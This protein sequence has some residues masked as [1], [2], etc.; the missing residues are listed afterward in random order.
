MNRRQFIQTGAVVSSAALPRS[1]ARSTQSKRSTSGGKR[2]ALVAGEPGGLSRTAFPLT[3]GIPFAPG[4]LPKGG[5]VGIVDSAG[6][7]TPVQTRVLESHRDGSVR[8]LL[9]D[10]QA[11]FKPFGKTRNELVLG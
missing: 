5:A 9:I 10:Y 8:W 7:A 3:V 11:D 6:R 4:V 1:Q 2:I